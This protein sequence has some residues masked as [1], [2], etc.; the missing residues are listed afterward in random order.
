M[1]SVKRTLRTM[2]IFF[3][4]VFSVVLHATEVRE[5]EILAAARKWIA[6]NAMF[7][8]ELPNAVPDKA[9]QMADF[10]GKAMPLWR[11][12]LQPTGYLVM[13]ADDTLPPVVAFNTIGAYDMPAAHP[14]PAM[15]NRQGAI[16]QK[17]L[18]KPKT[19][20]NEQAEKN[21]SRWNSLLGRTRVDSVMPS[22]VVTQPLLA[23]EWHQD[24]PYN[25][26]CPSGDGY[27]ERAITG[28]VALTVSQ[29]LK[30]HEWPPSGRGVKSFS[31][32]DSDIQ[33]TMKADYSFPYDWNLITD[34]YAGTD[35]KNYGM[36][37]FSVARL[38][39]EA[40]VLVEAD[41][42]L[43]ITTAYSHNIHE[44]IAKYL[45]YSN[46]AVYSDLRKGY[47]GYVSES[48]LYSRIHE[49]LAAGRPSIVAFDGHVFI[50]DGL[51]TMDGHDYYHFNYGWGS[52]HDG[53]YL[54][55][56]GYDDTVIVCATTNIQPSPVAAF[57]PMS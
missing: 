54:L 2:C 21:R 44:L 29:L 34:E 27:G 48:T 22:T 43:D 30:Y 20:G 19:R 9:V 38:V 1:N 45:G 4:V 49:D 55:S 24:S 7:Q 13:S 26:F 31:D 3:F 51:G 25:F 36:A 37:E 52:W 40:C 50:A 17:E 8:A 33:A 39:M 28:C 46:T 6:D 16:F 35:E 18:D 11:V 53:W 47:I 5:S 56:N 42:D 10:E 12:D 14:L 32:K 57:K 41:F 23:T 15:L